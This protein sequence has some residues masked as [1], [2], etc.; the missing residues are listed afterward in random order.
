[1][2]LDLDAEMTNFNKVKEIVLG[3]LVSEGLLDQSDAEEFTERC[4][5]LVYKGKWF[6]S[7][8]NKKMEGKDSQSYY[9]KMIEVEDKEDDV[10][11]LLRRTTS[12][13]DD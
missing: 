7:W 13:Y 11:R 3:K 5:V 6:S 2:S 9:I 12:N 1:M 8:F 4:H 10:D